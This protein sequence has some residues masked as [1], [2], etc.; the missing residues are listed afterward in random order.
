MGRHA[1]IGSCHS[2]AFDGL[3]KPSQPLIAAFARS[4]FAM[5]AGRGSAGIVIGHGVLE[6]S[7][8]GAQ[9]TLRQGIPISV[10]IGVHPWL[11]CFVRL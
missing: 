9:Y 2:P 4:Y 11:I 8:D 5:T 7:K 6:T 10:F 1:R 3:F